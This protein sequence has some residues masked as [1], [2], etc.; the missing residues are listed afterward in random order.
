MQLSDKVWSQ[1]RREVSASIQQLQ[2]L[3]QTLDLAIA[4]KAPLTDISEPDPIVFIE[5][6]SR[7]SPRRLRRDL[8]EDAFSDIVISLK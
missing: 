1:L 3:E 5:K 4:T 2:Q 8:G 6:T 7:R